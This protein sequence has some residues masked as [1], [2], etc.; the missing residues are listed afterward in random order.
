MEEYP[1]LSDRIQSTIIDSVLILVLFL[2]TS[3]I[4]DLVSNPPDFIRI[5]L[6]F[7]ILLGY[8][9]VC[10]TTGCTLGN[11][12]KGLRVRRFSNTAKRLNILQAVIR[13]VF[14]VVLGWLSFLTINAN[15]KR[16]AIHDLIAGSL[17]IRV[18]RN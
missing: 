9:P 5:I 6:F 8:E 7:G 13:Y 16:R 15:P 10:M 4:L 12:I 2:I 3:G 14:K 1:S 18:E 11:Y 17:M